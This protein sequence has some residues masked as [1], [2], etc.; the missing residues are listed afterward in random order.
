MQPV[1]HARLMMEYAT[2]TT[3]VLGNV[4]VH[5]RDLEPNAPHQMVRLL[6]VARP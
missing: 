5:P 6:V 3:A 1:P 2:W 4:C